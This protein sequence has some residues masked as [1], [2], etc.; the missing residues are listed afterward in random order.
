MP[1]TYSR[2]PPPSVTTVQVRLGKPGVKRSKTKYCGSKNVV[3]A[4]SP[5]RRVCVI[6]T[7]ATSGCATVCGNTRTLAPGTVTKTEMTST[8]NAAVSDAV[9][10]FTAA[11]A[12]AFTVKTAPAPAR[13]TG[14]GVLLR[15]VMV[16]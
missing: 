2:K 1:K 8:A 12:P 6:K 7:V 11:V 16:R 14:A 9:S 15:A 10:N 3:N 13:N 4:A 5:M